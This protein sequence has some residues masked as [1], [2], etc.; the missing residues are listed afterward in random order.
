M[1]MALSSTY[2]HWWGILWSI[3]CEHV[4][5]TNQFS[6]FH[7]TLKNSQYI[8]MSKNGLNTSLPSYANQYKKIIFIHLLTIQ[9]HMVFMKMEGNWMSTWKTAE[10]TQLK[11]NWWLN[12]M[13]WHKTIHIVIYCNSH[14]QKQLLKKIPIWEMINLWKVAA[15]PEIGCE[16]CS[17]FMFR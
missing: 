16:I 8:L 14:K 7:S 9:L 10:I 12:K 17:H 5:K 4:S 6:L 3:L 13:K 2:W 11:Q 1:E 15:A